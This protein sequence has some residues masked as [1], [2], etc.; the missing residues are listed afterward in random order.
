MVIKNVCYLHR[1]HPSAN[2]P[3]Y[4]SVAPTRWTS[5][6]FD[7]KVF[8]KTCQNPNLVKMGQECWELHINI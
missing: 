4:I 3:A 6:K 2:L 1:V 5:V 8:M 7:I